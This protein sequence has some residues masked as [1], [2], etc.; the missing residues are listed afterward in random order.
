MT[1]QNKRSSVP[2]PED[3]PGTLGQ[4]HRRWADTI[5]HRRLQASPWQGFAAAV[6]RRYGRPVAQGRTGEGFSREKTAQATGPA[7]EAPEVAEHLAALERTSP[8]SL[9][10]RSQ[11]ILAAILPSPLP[12]V[13]IYTNTLA[14]TI[15]RQFQADAL[16]FRNRILFRERAYAPHRREGL[17]LLGHE[18]THVTQSSLPGP[19]D[20]VE[21]LANE[22]KILTALEPA[23]E[24][25][26]PPYPLELPGRIMP[27]SAP[28][29]L[30][31]APG[32]AA[33]SGPAL[34]GRLTEAGAGPSLRAARSD[35]SLETSPLSA[36]QAAASPELSESHLRLIKEEVYRDIMQRIRSEFERGG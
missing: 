21:A 6:A 29:D 2:R 12:A 36:P 20:E 24:S 28:R 4:L 16:T 3:G 34:P 8:Q 30:A 10:Q 18:L 22:Q 5:M 26:R 19:G 13:R 7:A 23:R 35:R 11:E 1:H 25:I 32:M 27:S 31:F 17:A 15:A 33:P 14:D 9:D